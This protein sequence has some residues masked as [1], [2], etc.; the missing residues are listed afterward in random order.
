MLMISINVIIVKIPEIRIR[1]LIKRF[2]L[3][4]NIRQFSILW[5]V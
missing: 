1:N 5:R 3:S 2:G 4:S